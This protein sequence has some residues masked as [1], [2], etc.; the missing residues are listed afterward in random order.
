MR[1]EHAYAAKIL[2]VD[3]D[4]AIRTLLR[5]LLTREGYAV[6]LAEN[7]PRALECAAAEP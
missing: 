1:T 4:Q 2:V 5:H 6:H 7:G 3:D